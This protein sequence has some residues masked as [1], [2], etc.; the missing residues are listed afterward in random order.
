M[1][2]FHQP[3]LHVVALLLDYPD[4]ELLQ[5]LP[6]IVF[7]LESLDNAH[8]KEVIMLHDHIKWMQSL[9]PLQLEALYVNTFDWN[10]SCDLHLSN[11]ILPEDDRGRGDVLVR[12][13]EYYSTYG[14]APGARAL[15]DFL[16]VVLDFAATLEIEESYIFLSSADESIQ[17]LRN[18]LSE[19]QSP[20]ARL[21]EP[22]LYR[23]HFLSPISSGV[24]V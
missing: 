1:S 10:P 3:I 5:N 22:V 11:H 2:I 23:S 16:P 7:A 15:P 8:K 9:A 20:Y 12:L 6:E 18:N 17:I 21:L 4:D 24:S 19:I 14:W 13:L